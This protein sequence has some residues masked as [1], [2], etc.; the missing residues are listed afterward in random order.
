M[1]VRVYDGRVLVTLMAPLITPMKLLITIMT[2]LMTPKTGACGI[3]QWSHDLMH[4]T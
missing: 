1:S 2:L 4:V 3:V